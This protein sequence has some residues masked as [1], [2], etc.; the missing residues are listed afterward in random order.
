MFD[1]LGTALLQAVGFFG[2]FGFFV[3]QLLLDG[4]KPTKTQLGSTKKNLKEKIVKNDKPKKKGMFARK[5][6]PLKEEVKPKK[7]GLFGKKF[8]SKENLENPKKNLENPKKKR[9]FQ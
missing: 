1:N 3:Y 8:E 5:I 6:E 9:W 4:K 7:K 2:I